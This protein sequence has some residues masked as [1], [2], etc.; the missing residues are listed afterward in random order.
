LGNLTNKQ[1][2]FVEEYLLDNNGTQAAIRAGYSK[3]TARAIATE[4]LSKPVILDAIEEG[5]KIISEKVEITREWLI[6]E[7]VSTYEA[8][9]KESAFG[10]AFAG[11]KEIGV[12]TGHR[13]ER[14]EHKFTQDYEDRLAGAREK[15]NGD[16]PTAH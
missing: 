9:K 15:M 6:R 4:N 16:R 11:I 5:R 7:A 2:R 14:Q 8:A 1:S 12:L 13:V 10:P 3:H